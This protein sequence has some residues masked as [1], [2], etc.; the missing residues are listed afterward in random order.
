MNNGAID[1]K[2]I[3]PEQWVKDSI[4]NYRKNTGNE[5]GYGYSWWLVELKN[6]SSFHAIG[7]GGQ[8]IIVIPD[9]NMVIVTTADATVDNTGARNQYNSIIGIVEDHIIPAVKN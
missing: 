5:W 7:Y 4:R 9:L 1:K 6:H 3:I 8:Y 2:R